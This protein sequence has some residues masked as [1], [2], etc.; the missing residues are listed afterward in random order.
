MGAGKGLAATMRMA[1]VLGFDIVVPDVIA[2]WDA[3]AGD[4]P[5]EYERIHSILDTLH[6]G[7][8]LY[9]IGVEHGYMSVIYGQHVGGGNMVLVEPSPDFWPAIRLGWEQN[10]LD[11]PRASIEAY[12]GARSTMGEFATGWPESAFGP[13]SRERQPYRHMLHDATSIPTVTVDAIARYVV[14]PRGLTIDVEGAELLVL[15]GANDTL[16]RHGPDVWCSLHPDLLLKDFGSTVTD[17]YAFLDDVGYTSR[18]LRVD[19]ETHVHAVPAER[20]VDWVETRA[21]EWAP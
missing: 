11:T 18:V 3:V 15:R 4:S 13:E 9:D 16:L 8:V 1:R 20:A 10:G 7:D 2:D 21:P 19:H 5:W 17:F 14:P 12:V 6:P